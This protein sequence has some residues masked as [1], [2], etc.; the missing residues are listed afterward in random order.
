MAFSYRI[1]PAAV[2]KILRESLAAIWDNMAKV[3]VPSPTMESYKKCSDDYYR[4]W[5]FP[6]CVGSVDGKHV[7]IRAPPR[8]GS[9]FYN[10]KSHFSIVLLA[11]ADANY[12]FSFV[13]IG[14]KGSQSDSG[15]FANSVFGKK[16]Y[17]G[18]LPLPEDRFLP[19]TAVK[20]PYVFLG[21]EG[22]PLKINLMRP[23]PSKK[24]STEERIFNY[25]MCRSRRIVENAFG[26]W[27][28]RFR[29][30]YTTIHADLDLADL[31]V[32]ATVVLHNFLM[33]KND[34]GD[35]TMDRE[36]RGNV[37]EGSWREII[38]EYTGIENMAQCS[39]NNYTKTAA[40]VREQFKD[41]FNSEDGMVN[42][43]YEAVNLM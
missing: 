15:I 40:E 30:F 31:I 41:Y 12:K 37:S 42:W 32:K 2:C 24:L 16:I 13:D 6:S 29:I 4:K 22:F 17:D 33:T 14:A 36:G 43:Q 18:N 34:L 35:L 7:K 20:S 23:Y 3:Y 19:N 39:S 10:Y 27:A 28:A 21:D 9:D 38:R 11:V 5:N 26:L 1:S 25:R 8:S